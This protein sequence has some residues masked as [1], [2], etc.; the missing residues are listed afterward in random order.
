MKRLT[1]LIPIVLLMGTIVFSIGTD[2]TMP[3]SNPLGPP[4]G[5]MFV[6]SGAFSAEQPAIPAGA[7]LAE[8]VTTENPEAAEVVTEEAEEPLLAQLD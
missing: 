6:G 4:P 1:I 2:F 3:S 5:V 7:D 8:A